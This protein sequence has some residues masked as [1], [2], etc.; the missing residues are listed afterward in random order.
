MKRQRKDKAEWAM[1]LIEPNVKEGS[2]LWKT[3][4]KVSRKS[5][6][7]VI[8]KLSLNGVLV[9]SKVG[10]AEGLNHHFIDKIKKLVKELPS[11]TIN[12]MT[13]LK[14]K[15]TMEIPQMILKEITMEQLL[16]LMKGVKRTPSAGL[17]GISGLIL[18][19]IFEVIKDPLLHLM[20]LSQCSGIYPTIMKMTKIIPIVKTGKDPILPA[21]YRPVSNLSTIGK[22]LERGVMNQVDSHL[23]TNGLINKDQHGGRAAHSTTTC[24]TEITEDVRSAQEEKNHVALVAIDLS[25]AYDMVNHELLWEKCRVLNF[26]SSSLNFLKSFLKE[27]ASCV[28]LDGV[29][30]V[31]LR[32]GGQGVV[33]GGP[34]SGLLFNIYVNELPEQVNEGKTTSSPSDA[35]E[36]QFVDDGTL[37]SKGKS[38]EELVKNVKRDFKAIRDY[39]VNLRMVINPNKTQL[40]FLKPYADTDSL[41]VELEGT[42]IQHQKS[43]KILGITIGEDMGFDEHIWKGKTSITK[44]LHY[45]SSLIRTLKPFLPFHL[46]SQVGNAIINS[47]IQYCAPIW[48]PSSA[49]NRAKVQK[50]QIR[51]ARIVTGKWSREGRICHRQELL[52][53]MNWPNIDQ[54]VT[55]ATMNLMKEAMTG[56][57]S[58]KS[59]SYN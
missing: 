25:A 48:G 32:T 4:K 33:Q 43:I 27:R 5:N 16:K 18:H 19:D 1:K 11:P 3:V 26:C 10:M 7:N 51:A 39:L 14:K 20:N 30:S 50:A 52:S 15:K 57:S 53:K 45:K 2:H 40:M 42:T 59:K 54:M 31:M 56:H 9:S 13:E 35:S 58:E 36:K 34:S 6:L 21:S 47:T 22:L 8:E 49:G 41:D 37:I 28:D 46:L 55:I 23:R 17:D 38:H 12:L 44:N 29:R 24:L